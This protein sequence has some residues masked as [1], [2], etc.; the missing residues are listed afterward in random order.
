MWLSAEEMHKH[1]QAL[2]EQLLNNCNPCE[3]CNL[4]C[5]GIVLKHHHIPDAKCRKHYAG[6]RSVIHN[7]IRRK[8]ERH[9]IIA[10]ASE[11]CNVTCGLCA[12]WR[13]FLD[14]GNE[15]PQEP[16]KPFG[17]PGSFRFKIGLLP[18]IFQ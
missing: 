16:S 18:M 1:C 6:A 9:G 8:N 17:P 2:C 14:S 4:C 7:V 3:E 12:G 15:V 10:T 5:V 13:L 11:E